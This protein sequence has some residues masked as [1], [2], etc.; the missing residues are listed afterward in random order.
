MSWEIGLFECGDISL[1]LYSWFFPHFATAEAKAVMDGS[2]VYVNS[3]CFNA[4]VT[5]W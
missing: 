5:R 1:C 4:F 2:D 3:C